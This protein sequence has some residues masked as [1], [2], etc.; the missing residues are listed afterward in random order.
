LAVLQIRHYVGGG[1]IYRSTNDA[2]EIILYVN[3][4]LAMTIGLERVRGRTGSIVHD[5][6]AQVVAGL[7]VLA[8]IGALISSASPRFL[9]MPVG[10]GFF[11]L[12]LLGYGLPALLAIVLALI[13]RTTRPFAY[14]IAA[15]V[16]AV[17]LALFYLTLE[18]RRLF[19]GPVL[20]GPI[21]DA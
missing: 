15:T 5:I 21:S 8:I 20:A 2:V 18:T 16:T 7:T 10:G 11:N 4:G 12:I 19:H 13:A 17:V 3:V 14:R 6:G 1:D 9:N